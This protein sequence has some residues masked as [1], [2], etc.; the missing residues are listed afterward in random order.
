MKGAIILTSSKELTAQ[1]YT[2]SRKLDTMQRFNQNRSTSS[3]QMKS[4]IVEFLSPDAKKGEKEMSEYELCNIGLANAVNNASWNVTDI[5]FSS[6]VV[7]SYIM[8]RKKK[9]N[10]F[11]INPKTIIV[12]EF[13]E[14][15]QDNQFCEHLFKI[16]KFFGTFS[17]DGN[18]PFSNEVNRHRQF[19]FCASSIPRHFFNKGSASSLF[20]QNGNN[21]METMSS[22]FDAKHI[23][24][25]NTHK[26]SP[27]I[28]HEWF[29]MQ[30]N[31]LVKSG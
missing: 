23:M 14:Q 13:D 31:S 22:M 29:D 27:L 4:P 9:N 2:Q 6:P 26:I 15:I 1:I 10:P 16:L 7:M 24:S 28:E 8:D 3:L 11:D 20:S 18:T 17:D 21:I 12:D 30:K 19:I 5:L 25:E